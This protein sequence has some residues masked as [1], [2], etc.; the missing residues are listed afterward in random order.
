[1]TSAG[2]QVRPSTGA[3]ASPHSLAS[4][5]ALGAVATYQN[6]LIRHLPEPPL[7]L[8]DADAV[9]ASDGLPGIKTPGPRR[10]PPAWSVVMSRLVFVIASPSQRA[11]A[12]P[13]SLAGR[14]DKECGESGCAP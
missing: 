13:S 14:P 8:L 5:G 2:E 9:D 6:G 10:N 12:G 1:M 11:N 7:P 3:D 4:I